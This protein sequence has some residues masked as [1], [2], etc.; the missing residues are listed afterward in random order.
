ML[1]GM[2]MSECARS[3]IGPSKRFWDVRWMERTLFGGL[4]GACLGIELLRGSC[5]LEL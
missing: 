4:S 5:C 3:C 2:V 1:S